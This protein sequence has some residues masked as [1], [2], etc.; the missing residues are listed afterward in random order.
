[1][2][3]GAWFEPVLLRVSTR[4]GQILHWSRPLDL[5]TAVFA[6]PLSFFYDLPNAL[7]V[8]AMGLSFIAQAA[9]MAF[10]F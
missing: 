2:A 10:V 1:M 3:G 8:G 5:L 9:T 7:V 4:E 6:W